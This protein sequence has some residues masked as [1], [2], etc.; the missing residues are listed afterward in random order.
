L[1]NIISEEVSN[2]RSDKFG[3]TAA[4]FVSKIE[5]D[6]NAIIIYKHLLKNMHANELIKLMIDLIPDKLA[7]SKLLGDNERECDVY[8]KIYNTLYLSLPEEKRYK[9]SEKFSAVLRDDSDLLVDVW[10]KSLFHCSFLE[11]S[12]ENDR[13]IIVSYYEGKLK[14]K[15]LIGLLP[16]IINIFNYCTDDIKSNILW[17]IIHGYRYPQKESDK[18]GIVSFLSGAISLENNK[19]IREYLE[20]HSLHID[21]IKKLI[22]EID[23][24][25][26]F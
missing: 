8:R 15:D 5:K 10:G 17:S 3:C 11:K 22:Q 20:K 12:N 16:K 14:G 19:F 7:D 23:E 4:Q 2:A 18:A 1:L 25:P 6:S 13:P 24:E 26:P 9:I 21:E